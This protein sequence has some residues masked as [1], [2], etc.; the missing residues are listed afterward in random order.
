M[1]VLEL[2]KKIASIPHCSGDTAALRD[3][4]LDFAKRCGFHTTIDRAGNILCYRRKR[5]IC[6]QAHYDMV[7]VGDAPKIELIQENG[8][9]RAKNSS[10]GAD[11]G[12]GVAIM[13]A[14]MQEQKEAEFLFTN[15]EEIGLVGAANLELELQA[16]AMINLDSE[17]F[18]AIYV[19]CAGGADVSATKRVSLKKIQG[20]FFKIE[21]RNFLGGHSGVDIDKGIPSAI[22]EFAFFIKDAKVGAITAGERRNSIPATLKAIVASQKPLVSN[23]FF[24]VTIAEPVMVMDEPLGAIVRA[25]VQGVRGW[26]KEFH[27]PYKSANLALIEQRGDEL[28]IATSVRANSDEA[29]DRLIAQEQAFF[30]N[31]GFE[32]E[33]SGKYPAWPP[34]ITSLAQEIQKRYP[35]EAEFKAIHA[36]LECAVFAKRYPQMEIV[37]IGPTIQNPHSINERIRLDEIEPIYSIVRGLL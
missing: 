21:A 26:H 2:F 10:L 29:L 33:V 14:L 4:I 35:R 27:I 25:Y 20:E 23:R 11:N 8:W 16:K 15:D 19:G 12:I 13:L 9:L 1:V 5:D 6:V 7:C 22:E 34:K 17:E 37:S 18:G 36:G 31:L 32:V 30:E 28:F 3:F 24:E